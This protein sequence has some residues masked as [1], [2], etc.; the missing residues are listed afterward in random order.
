MRLFIFA[1]NFSDLI[2]GF[3]NILPETVV[4]VCA[5]TPI[6][7][8][9]VKIKLKNNL[10]FIFLLF[11]PSQNGCLKAKLMFLTFTVARAVSESH[12]TSIA[13]LLFD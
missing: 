5:E 1:E 2:N 8:I 4:P 6:A 3:V 13:S 10:D 9:S 7:K 12:R 11:C